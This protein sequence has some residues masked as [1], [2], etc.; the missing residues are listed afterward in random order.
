MIMQIVTITI[1]YKQL[2]HNNNNGSN[3]M[4]IKYP[5]GRAARAPAKRI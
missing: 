1:N 4:M 2:L 3:N 5:E